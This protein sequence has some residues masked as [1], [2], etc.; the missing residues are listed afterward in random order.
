MDNFEVLELLLSK[1]QEEYLD[2][3]DSPEDLNPNG[4]DDNK[5]SGHFGSW[6]YEDGYSYDCSDCQS[7]YKNRKEKIE[8]LESYIKALEEVLYK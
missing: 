1:I 4:C 6:S 7:Y 8:V 2:V 5:C 3:L